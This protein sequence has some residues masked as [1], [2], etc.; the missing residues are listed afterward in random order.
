MTSCVSKR[1]RALILNES[2]F[3][4]VV[5]AMGVEPMSEK[6][7]VQVSP[8]AGDLQH[9]RRATPIVRLALW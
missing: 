6:S 3:F 8:G 7:S 2:T 5:E 1:K 9:S 4:L